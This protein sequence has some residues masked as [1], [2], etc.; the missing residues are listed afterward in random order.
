M[1]REIKG[2]DSSLHIRRKPLVFAA[3]AAMGFGRRFGVQ[4]VYGWEP[5]KPIKA[6]CDAAENCRSVGRG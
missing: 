4:Q 2:I 6:V 5:E 3:D 1:P